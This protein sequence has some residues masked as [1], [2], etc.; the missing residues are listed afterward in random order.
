MSAQ[1]AG[2]YPNS[3]GQM[4]YWDGNA[5]GQVQQ[6]AQPTMPP[7]PAPA[8]GGYPPAAYAG[9]PAYGYGQQMPA[10]LQNAELASWGIRVGAS[11]LDALF[12]IFTLFIGYIVNIFLMGR[13]GEKNGMTLGKQLCNIRVVKEDGAPVTAGY[14]ALR[15]IVIRWLLFGIVGGFFLSIPT[16]LDVLWPLWDD[17]NQALHDKVASSYVVRA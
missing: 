13:E 6:T 15:E 17:K 5:W 7:P 2:W 9:A 10:V 14:A 1:P 12:A 16:L 3:Q 4:Q 11:L 8:V